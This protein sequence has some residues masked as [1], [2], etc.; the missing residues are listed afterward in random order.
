MCLKKKSYKDEAQALTIILNRQKEDAT[1]GYLRS[2]LCPLCY[3]WH[4]TSKQK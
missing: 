1:V 4:L 3:K 2:Y